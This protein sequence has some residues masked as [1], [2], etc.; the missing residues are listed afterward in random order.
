MPS[1]RYPRPGETRSSLCVA[2]PSYHAVER[3]R[4]EFGE[5][6]RES[7]VFRCARAHAGMADGSHSRESSNAVNPPLRNLATEGSVSILRAIGRATMARTI[8][9]GRAVSV[10]PGWLLGGRFDTGFLLGIPTLAICS[11]AIVLADER[12]F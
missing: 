8:S 9:V 4:D 3:M 10:A 11:G 5:Y 6:S 2:G 7:R 1:P 12:F